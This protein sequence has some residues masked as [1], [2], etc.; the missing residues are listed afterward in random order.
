MHNSPVSDLRKL[1]QWAAERIG[2]YRERAD[3][4][5]V[6]PSVELQRVRER[7]GGQ[8]PDEG[9]DPS[10]VVD[11]LAAAV[12]PALVTSVGPRY[13]GY[14]I[15]GSLEAAMAADLLTAGWDQVA[16]NAT[17]SPAGAIVEAGG[18]GRVQRG[19][20][21][22]PPASFGVVTRAQGAHT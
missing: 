2:D 12:E 7:L 22:S 18:G 1:L 9:L 13:F 20:G 11:E 6:A 5:P 8:L 14:V 17:T 15:G 10:S 4:L 16:F 21:V 19:F 3:R